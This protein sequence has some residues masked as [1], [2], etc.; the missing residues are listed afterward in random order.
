[1]K[2][3]PIKKQTKDKT[4]GIKNPI[5]KIF[6]NPILPANFPKKYSN[7]TKPWLLRSLFD[8]TRGLVPSWSVI[9]V[10]FL[11]VYR[12]SFRWFERDLC[13]FSAIWTNCFMHL[14]WT[15]VVVSAPFSITHNF[16]SYIV[17]IRRIFSRDTPSMHT[18]QLHQHINNPILRCF[19]D[20]L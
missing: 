3:F 14:T 18:E 13:L 1:M 20:K 9:L 5:L 6:L 8:H 11:A 15:A 16:H 19:W 2:I 12:T 4:A 7:K 17:T 10:A